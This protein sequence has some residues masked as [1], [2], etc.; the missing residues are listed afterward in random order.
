MPLALLIMRGQCSM[1]DLAQSIL[2]GTAALHLILLAAVLLVYARPALRVT[3]Q[4][5]DSLAKMALIATALHCF[6]TTEEFATGFYVE[7]PE[8]L[9]LQPWPPLF[10]IG[11]NLMWIAVWCLSVAGLYLPARV[12]QV[13]LWF[14][15]LASAVNGLAHPLLALAQWAYF[16]GLWTSPLVGAA[17]IVLIRRMLVFGQSSGVSSQ[18]M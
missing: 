5:R 15:A 12:V 13:P 3:G 10:F 2:L 16:P 11:F 14:L 9:G 4:S 7:F 6:H 8:L 17:G 18:P 1:V